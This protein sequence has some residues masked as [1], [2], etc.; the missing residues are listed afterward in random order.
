MKGQHQV[1]AALSPGT[2]NTKLIGPQNPSGL[3]GQEKNLWPLLEL[4]NRIVQSK[5]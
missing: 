2:I 4:E 1:Q 3:L 5:V